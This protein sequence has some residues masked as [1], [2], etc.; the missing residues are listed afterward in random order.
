MDKRPR[1]TD[2]WMTVQECAAEFKVSVDVIYDA[3]RTGELVASRKGKRLIRIRRS[4]FETWL[5]ELA[6]SA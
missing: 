3:V 6:D 5:N 4:S 1:N 2:E